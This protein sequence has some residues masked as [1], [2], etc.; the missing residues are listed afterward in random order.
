[1]P[2]RRLALLTIMR[3]VVVPLIKTPETNFMLAMFVTDCVLRSHDSL[4]GILHLASIPGW[5][6]G[7]QRFVS[8]RREHHPR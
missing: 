2:N 6:A 7:S 8:Y 3:G 4:T 1:M 5:M